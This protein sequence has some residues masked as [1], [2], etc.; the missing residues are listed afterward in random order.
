MV[1]AEMDDLILNGRRL[2]AVGA[3][4]RS[5]GATL[6]AASAV[7]SERERQLKQ[8]GRFPLAQKFD[9]R[10]AFVDLRGAGYLTV[11]FAIFVIVAAFVAVFITWGFKGVCTVTG[12]AYLAS[13]L[14]A[15]VDA[16]FSHTRKASLTGLAACAALAF[17]A[18]IP[19]HVSLGISLFAASVITYSLLVKYYVS[20]ERFATRRGSATSS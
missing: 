17:T 13:A 18:V 2:E 4:R 16:R 8:D 3:Y 7:V 12:L 15:L 14:F 5:T 20:N 10:I 11:A 9:W 19:M 1:T 6:S